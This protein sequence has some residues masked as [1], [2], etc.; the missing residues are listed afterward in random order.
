MRM[1]YERTIRE[2]PEEKQTTGMSKKD[3]YC[4][5][6]DDIDGLRKTLVRN[7]GRQLQ[8]GWNFPTMWMT[9]NVRDGLERSGVITRIG[10]ER[11]IVFYRLNQEYEHILADSPE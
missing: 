11:G 5:V 1:N 4:A 9:T 10:P 6:F 8:N 7:H 2:W 3:A